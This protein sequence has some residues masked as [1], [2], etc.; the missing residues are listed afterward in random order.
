M[1]NWEKHSA[2]ALVACV[3]HELHPNTARR[4]ERKKR[5]KREK[6][7]RNEKLRA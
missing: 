4:G 7:E 3:D 2:E 6:K 1:A 5:R